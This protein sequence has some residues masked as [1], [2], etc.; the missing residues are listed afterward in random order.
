MGAVFGISAEIIPIGIIG[1]NYAVAAA[2]VINELEV[3][4]AVDVNVLFPIS[5]TV[6]VIGFIVFVC[7]LPTYI[8]SVIIL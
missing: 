8:A 6:P 1:K 4:D 5:I 2:Y 3:G 7:K